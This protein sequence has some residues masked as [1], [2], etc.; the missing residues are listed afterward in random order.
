M[1]QFAQVEDFILPQMGTDSIS[2][3]IELATME[4]IISTYV[5]SNLDTN[6]TPSARNSVVAELWD[7]YLSH[8]VPDPDMRPERFMEL[9]ERVPNSCRQSHDQLYRAMNTFLQVSFHNSS[10]FQRCN[11]I[12]L[13]QFE[14]NPCQIKLGDVYLDDYPAATDRYI[15][16]IDLKLLDYNFK[17]KKKIMKS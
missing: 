3:S 8:V 12:R 4:S 2:S 13:D 11:L 9:I 7:V 5:S 14:S 1:L 16:R 10:I 15:S 6:H 17:R